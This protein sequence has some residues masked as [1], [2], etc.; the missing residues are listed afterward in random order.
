V[1]EPIEHLPT[2][3]IETLMTVVIGALPF[4]VGLL[5]VSSIVWWMVRLFSAGRP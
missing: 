1:T 5:V 3:T 4:L 2:L